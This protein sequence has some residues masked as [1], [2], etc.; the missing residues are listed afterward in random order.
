MKKYLLVPI[1]VL[2][3]LLV[4]C[5]NNKKTFTVNFFD[6][7]IL[8]KSEEVR[9]GANAT[10]P[11]ELVKE[12]YDFDKWSTDFT[13]IKGNLDVF[14][15][16]KIK[17]FTVQFFSD[18][19]Q[20]GID[21]IIEYNKSAEAPAEPKKDGMYF[22]GWD[23]DFSAVKS[24]LKINAKFSDNPFFKVTYVDDISKELLKTEYVE[25][26]KNSTPPIV[27]D[28]HV[29]YKFNNWS[30]EGLNITSDTE[31]VA[32][33]HEVIEKFAI[34]ADSTITL[35]VSNDNLLYNTKVILTINPPS[36]QVLE[37]LFINDKRVNTI[38]NTFEFFLK[39]NIVITVT[40]TSNQTVQIFYLND[41]H[42]S[43][44]ENIGEYSHEMGLAKI[45]NFIQ[46]KRLEN[47][48]SIFLAGGDMLQGSALS[49]YYQGQSTLKLL[50]M[51]GLDVFT[52]GNHEFD[53]GIEEVTK[54]FAGQNPFVSFPLVSANIYK[55]GT[56]DLVDEAVPYHIIERA[57][58]KFGVIG[59]IGSGLTSSISA[60]RVKDYEFRDPVPIVSD[61]AKHLREVEKVNIVITIGHDGMSTTTSQ[62][63]NLTGMSKVD[64]MFNAHTHSSYIDLS[65]G[66]AP[67]IQSRSNGV[68]VGFIEVSN[69]SQVIQVNDNS[70]M[71]FNYS[72]SNL[73]NVE[74]SAILAQI[75]VYKAETDPVFKAFIIANNNEVNRG[76]FA[77]WLS[78]LITVKT[79]SDVGIFN[80]GG[81]RDVLPAGDITIEKLYKVLPFDNMIKSATLQGE[82]VIREINREASYT[83]PNVTVSSSSY[84][85]I[86][87][88]EYVFDYET[89]VYQRYGTDYVIYEGNIR[90]WVIE[91]MKLQAAAHLSFN[92][93]NPIMSQPVTVLGGA[94]DGVRTFI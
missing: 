7:D 21:Q 94:S 23:Q 40:Y 84:Y 82:Y 86:V 1:I 92:V 63:R 29:G 56:N 48:N 41:F 91:E 89:G 16:F 20:I 52:I 51:M 10:A 69:T 53:W 87:T 60:G 64:L 70:A 5:T 90:E 9:V 32:I 8:L 50:D 24:D 42:G 54:S 79:G 26:G 61:Y 68:E 35:N 12:G 76:D 81:V 46:Q 3:L 19:V 39:E 14:A 73:F 18:G 30:H 72:S 11:T 55:K 85:Q 67:V 74:D 37:N 88:N 93:T 66:K 65:T 75:E 47:P 49:N 13:N 62:I 38:N 27:D 6:G 22:T 57:G 80:Y 58:I 59:Y 77:I 2:I 17:T 34:V 44:T 36:D 25:L 31:I 45:A 28:T 15:V 71:N 43:I 83:K 78:K 4:A 33:Y